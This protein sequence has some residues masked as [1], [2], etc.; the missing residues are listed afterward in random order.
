MRSPS[1]PVTPLDHATL[2]RTRPEEVNPPDWRV[3]WSDGPW[4]IKVYSGGDRTPLGRTAPLDRV[5]LHTFAIRR[6]RLDPRGGMPPSPDNPV[7]RPLGA[8]FVARRPIP[9]GGAMY[10]TEAYALLTGDDRVC[11]YDPY[12]HELTDLRHPSPRAALRAAL[13]MPASADLPPAV[14]VLTNRFWKTFYKYGDFAWRLGAVD[15]GVALGRVLALAEA[16][17]G[18]ADVRVDFDD[19]ALNR[20]LGLDGNHESA[21]AVVGLGEAAPCPSGLATGEPQPPAT[22]ERSKRIKRSPRF[23]AMHNASVTRTAAEPLAR[24]AE[25][26]RRVNAL[27]AIALDPAEDVDP[28]GPDVLLYRTSNGR[29]FDGRPASTSRVATVLSLSVDALTRLRRA[30]D[31]ALAQGVDLYCA[32]HRVEGVPRGWYRYDHPTGRLVASGIGTGDD[33]AQVL[34]RAQL[35]DSINIELAAFTVHVV[36]PVD[37]LAEGRGV[38]G[39][40]EQQFAVGAAVDALTRAAAAAGLGSHPVLGF[41]AGVVDRAYGLP[42]GLGA[43]AQVSVGLTRPPVNW[44]ISVVPDER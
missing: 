21:Y 35:A 4:P 13:G 26:A 25:P 11:H 32:T 22:L 5:L 44:E 9:S 28:L 43:H 7:P 37:F 24:Q 29:R 38:R 15:T 30:S 40:R 10:P 1:L 23:D 27:P 3:D 33:S 8:L 31:Q 41:N 39:Y 34:Q 36:A 20:L 17:Y 18:S 2:L 19:T 42:A 14:L 12:R 6:V 16:A